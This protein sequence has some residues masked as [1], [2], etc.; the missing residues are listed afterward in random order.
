M[1]RSPETMKISTENNNDESMNINT[2]LHFHMCLNGT[3]NGTPLLILFVN[4]SSL[5]PESKVRGANIGP[6]WGRQNPDGPHVGPMNF[7]IWGVNVCQYNIAE[8]N[9]PLFQNQIAVDW[10]LVQYSFVQIKVSDNIRQYVSKLISYFCGVLQAYIYG[11]A[12]RREVS[13]P[14]Y[15][16]STWSSW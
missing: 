10:I 14:R 13:K 4:I 9:N 5:V 11:K 15:L 3:L 2:V 7:V 6:I 16:V 1:T 8:N 12:R